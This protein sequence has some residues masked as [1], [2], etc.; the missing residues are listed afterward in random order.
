MEKGLA[1]ALTSVDNIRVRFIGSP[2]LRPAT[3]RS[4]LMRRLGFAGSVLR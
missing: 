1:R 4:L 3:L 2:N